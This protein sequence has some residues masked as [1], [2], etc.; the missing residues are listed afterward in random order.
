MAYRTDEQDDSIVIDGFEQGIA[1]SPYLGIGNMQGLNNSYY[2]GV[3]Y[4]NYKRQGV[5]LSA[6]WFAGA[7]STNVSN[8]TGW[9]FTSSGSS[10]VIGNPVQKATSPVGL[11]Y[12]LDDTGQ[13]W[14]QT[15]VGSNAFGFLGGGLGRLGTGSGGLAYWNNYLVVFGGGLI[16][17]C[18]DG[19]N[20]SGVISTNWNL[21]SSGTATNTAV[22]TTNFAVSTSNLIFSYPYY[23][24]FLPK[25]QV[26]DPVKFTTTGTLPT[27]LAL[28][29]T[30]YI[31]TCPRNTAA[32][33]P[34]TVSATI[35]GAAVTFSDNGTGVHTIT[36]YG[37]PL[38]LGN[39][40]NIVFT[41]TINDS[42]TSFTFSSYVNPSGVT[43]GST[44]NEATGNYFIVYPDG[45]KISGLFTNGS[46][47]ISINEP[48]LEYLTS[49]A[50]GNINIQLI[51][52]TITNY[53]PYISKTDGNLY[54]GNGRQIGRILAQNSSIQF[55]P[56]LPSS[57]DISANVTALLIS[58]DTVT[59]MTDSKDTLVVTGNKDIY[60][61][62]YVSPT[63]DAPAPIGE[64][65]VKTINIL[66]NTY[67]LAGNKGN[68]YISNGY[69]AQLFYKI[70]DYIAGVIDPIFLYGDI[71]NHRSKLTFQ[72]L[73]QNSLGT[74][75]SAGVFSLVVSSPDNDPSAMS[76]C[77]DAVNSYGSLPTQGSL[78]TGIL[79]SNETV[80]YD[81]YYSGWSSTSTTGGIDYNDT[82]VVSTSLVETDIIPIGTILDKKTLGN[83]EFKLDRPMTAGDTISLYWR[84]SLSDTYALL[85]TTTT[86]Q[87][88][89]YFPSKVS[90]AQWAQFKAVMVG[91]GTSRIPLHEIRIHTT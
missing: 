41:G 49:A 57:Y 58:G 82:T 72:L 10:I 74:N 6:I 87:L 90:Q 32:G 65:V 44:W 38:P 19:S 16:E 78:Q 28:N 40:T 79:I 8:N 63:V 39:C 37:M 81:K 26:N 67:I 89:D 77:Q 69:S 47:T 62:D 84:P 43:Q 23:T 48:P 61:W 64:Q 66:N 88:S 68:I 31:K 20:D 14:K 12:I 11:N 53:C 35:G 9:F 15:S 80:G 75:I 17:F 76:F 54:F 50:S 4:L 52:T 60:T 73:I 56:G 3:V 70:P 21:N 2:P 91:G 25:F 85:G 18:G 83:I 13:I 27:G 7:N 51:D 42:S 36:D 86:T 59:S 34:V 30:Y 22:F 29:T 46:G 1:P 45:N 5:T 71:M 33:G 55:N 24:I